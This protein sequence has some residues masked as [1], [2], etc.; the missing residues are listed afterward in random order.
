MASEV[1][2]ALLMS[3][4]LSLSP[5]IANFNKMAESPINQE[6]RE[7]Q[8]S[9]MGFAQERFGRGL[10]RIHANQK[11]NNIFKHVLNHIRVYLRSSAAS[12]SFGVRRPVAALVLGDLSPILR[13]ETQP[14]DGRDWSRPT[15]ALTGQRT[16]N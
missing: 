12:S 10:T 15:K 2:V 3:V 6:P 14:N 1:T 8:I 5:T 4:G 7:M 11:Q 16:P 13:I 9:F